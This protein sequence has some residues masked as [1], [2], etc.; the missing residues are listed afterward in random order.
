MPAIMTPLGSDQDTYHE[1]D[2]VPLADIDAKQAAGA[3]YQAA[4]HPSIT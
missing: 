2:F 1:T 4:S 3:W